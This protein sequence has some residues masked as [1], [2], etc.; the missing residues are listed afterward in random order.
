M[1][2]QIKTLLDSVEIDNEKF[3][4]ENE[5]TV[6]DYLL[7][8]T[9]AEDQGFLFYLTENEKE[10]FEK[11]EKKAEH[12]INEIVSFISENYNYYL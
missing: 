5:M 7:E 9:K 8:A 10:E 12:H 11:D 3:I 4:K 2:H 6:A 1:K